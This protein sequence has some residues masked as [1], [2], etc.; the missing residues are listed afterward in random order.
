M[1][2]M[3]LRISLAFVYSFNF[4]PSVFTRIVTVWICEVKP[5]MNFNF[6][7]QVYSFMLWLCQR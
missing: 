5:A 4:L 6:G 2:V 7:V 1:F 3:C